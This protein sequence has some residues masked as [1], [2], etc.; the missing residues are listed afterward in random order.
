M[1]NFSSKLTVL[2]KELNKNKTQTDETTFLDKI[3]KIGANRLQLE[4]V[5]DAYEKAASMAFEK[6]RILTEKYHTC[7]SKSIKKQLNC[8]PGRQATIF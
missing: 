7:K 5:D 8:L 2:F 6:M 4:F 1:D 3:G